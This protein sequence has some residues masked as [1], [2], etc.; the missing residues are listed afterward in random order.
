MDLEPREVSLPRQHVTELPQPDHLPLGRPGTGAAAPVQASVC[1]CALTWQA[2]GRPEEAGCTCVSLP[3]GRL[4]RKQRH[5]AETNLVSAS[6]GP[7][8]S[9]W[10]C[11]TPPGRWR[12]PACSFRSHFARPEFGAGS[13]QGRM[14]CVATLGS[15][16]P[17]V[18]VALG[19][20]LDR[21]AG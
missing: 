11:T 21:K 15:R 9:A 16:L 3:D 20:L 7:F 4:K 10:S 17:P 8:L 1:K 18:F 19:W 13:E 6:L 12:L 2:V 5:Q 14:H